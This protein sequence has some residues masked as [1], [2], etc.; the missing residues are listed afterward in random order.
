MNEIEAIKYQQ[1]V[2]DMVTALVVRTCGT[3][4]KRWSMRCPER[5][6]NNRVPKDDDSCSAWRTIGKIKVGLLK[7]HK[8]E[9]HDENH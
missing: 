1:K 5:K 8:E 6:Q 7:K 4:D 9:D 3:C 2:V